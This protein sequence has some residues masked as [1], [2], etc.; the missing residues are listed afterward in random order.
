MFRGIETQKMLVRSRWKGHEVA[1][2]EPTSVFILMIP[3]EGLLETEP[4]NVKDFIFDNW[5][6]C[7]K[8]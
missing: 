4:I 8:E 5:G 6:M 2:K 1:Q 7:S 3:D